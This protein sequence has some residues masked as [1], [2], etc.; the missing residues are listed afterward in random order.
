MSFSLAA[1][2]HSLFIVGGPDLA[3]KRVKLK[4]ARLAPTAMAV[5]KKTREPSPGGSWARGP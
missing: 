3:N 2:C 1:S 5:P 4:R